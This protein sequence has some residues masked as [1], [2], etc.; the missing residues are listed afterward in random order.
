MSN[1]R[2]SDGR[3]SEPASDPRPF[4]SAVVTA[5]FT[6]HSVLG[7]WTVHLVAVVSTGHRRKARQV[8]FVAIDTS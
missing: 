2:Q 7:Q 5:A 6:R 3:Q 1:G 8:S 4:Y